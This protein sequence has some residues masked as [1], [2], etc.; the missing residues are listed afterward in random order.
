M[1]TFHRSDNLF[2]PAMSVLFLVL[3][4]SG[5]FAYFS[6]VASGHVQ[7][8]TVIHIH[9]LASSLWVIL[10]A[11]QVSLVGAAQTNWHRRLGIVGGVL[12]VA[13]IVSGYLVA[14]HAAKRGFSS[15]GDD[16]LSF[17]S[18]TLKNV[19]VFAILVSAGLCFR[20]NPPAHKRLMYLATAAGL[21]LPPISRL[22]E[23]VGLLAILVLL[24]AGPIYDKL[25]H[26]AVHA[27]YKWG[28]PFGI[29]I[30]AIQT[31]VAPTAIWLRF[32]SWLTQ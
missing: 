13:V 25:R 14:I 23:L 9:A 16:P 27:A 24:F 4:V 5:F 26:G 19:V 17:L 2:F 22:P 1:N 32:A 3:V 30:T 7:E 20:N 18:I 28:I 10:F 21:M 8:P 6:A 31:M 11:V 29:G 15:T 12:V